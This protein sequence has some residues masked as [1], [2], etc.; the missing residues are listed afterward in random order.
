MKKILVMVLCFFSTIGLAM[1]QEYPDEEGK[2]LEEVRRA[3]VEA[4]KTEKEYRL[5]EAEYKKLLQSNPQ[6][7]EARVGLADVL[8][9]QKRYAEAIQEYK[10]ALQINPESQKIKTRLAWVYFWNQDYKSAEALFTELLQEDPQDIAIKTGLADLYAY[11]GNLKKAT[12]LYKELL[13]TEDN[14][15]ILEKLADALTWS[16]QHKKALHLYNEILAKKD[17]P[18]V[19]LQ[20]ARVLGYLRR[21]TA[22]TQEYQRIL[23]ENYDQEIEL[24]MKARRAQWKN[25]TISAIGYYEDIIEINPENLDVLFNLSQLY[26]YSSQWQ[27]A[28]KS[29]RQIL[30][31]LP[32]HPQAELALRKVRLISR[33]LSVEPAYEYIRADSTDRSVDIHKSM[34]SA[35]GT[36]PLGKL[37]YSF[38]YRRSERDFN[39]FADTSEDESEF[40][41]TY[42]AGLRWRLNGFYN[43]ISY[44]NDIDDMETYGG[45]LNFRFFDLGVWSMGFEKERLENNSKVI[46]QGLYRDSYKSRLDLDIS[47]RVTLGLDYLYADY[48]EDNTVNEPGGDITYLLLFEPVQLSLQYR[49]SMIDFDREIADY[50]SPQ[51]F[52]VN[53]ITLHWRHFLSR[54]TS[55]FGSN[56][57]FYDLKYTGSQDSAEV[58]SHNYS[59]SLNW[60]I[61]QRLRLTLEG[62]YGTSN[63]SVYEDSRALASLKLY[64]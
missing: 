7:Q 38:L 55:F 62:S 60:D 35:K 63:P 56:D 2:E 43:F 59:A 31:L 24:E 23:N 14:L 27:E 61:V 3:L 26:S 28:E 12:A 33:H 47:P 49:Y 22:A 51:E 53:S 21:Y 5:A 41:F 40:S 45:N 44:D 19:R 46:R 10:I 16:G 39:D 30:R 57:L 17:D 4:Y 11:S 64:F 50:F 58:V 13:A 15:E 8:T 25:R 54:A 20:K 6:D 48:S 42:L 9:Q 1:A 32:G 34:Y 37:R 29:Y 52:S 18:K 36:L